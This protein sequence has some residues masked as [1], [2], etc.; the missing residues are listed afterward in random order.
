MFKK[1]KIKIAII[2]AGWFGCH[3]GYELKKKILK[4]IYMKKKMIFLKMVQETIQID[5]I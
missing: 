5:F 4:W 1:K 2:G 3:I